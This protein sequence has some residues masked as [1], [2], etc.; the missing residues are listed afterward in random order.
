MLGHPGASVPTHSGLPSAFHSLAEFFVEV[1]ALGR[2]QQ[3]Q[4]LSTYTHT[5]QLRE[6]LVMNAIVD[7]IGDN[8][9][10][11]RGHR[12]EMG[13]SAAVFPNDLLPNR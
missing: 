10:W 13:K 7:F 8:T 1:E 6:H 4:V 9:D 3:A 12:R 5:H 2:V 11:V